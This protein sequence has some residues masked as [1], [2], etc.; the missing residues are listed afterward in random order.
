M[1]NQELIDYL[2]TLDL[3]VYKHASN[4]I[5]KFD[6]LSTLSQTQKNALPIIAN[7][8]F[9]FIS[10]NNQIIGYSEENIISRTVL[11]NNYY[12]FINANQYDNV[13]TSQGKFRPTILEEFM[14]ILFK[15]LINE[16]KVNL[17][18][19]NN[20]L[21]VGSSRA[22]TNLF[23]SGSNFQEFVNSPQIGI[24]DKDQDFAIYRPI[25]IT[26][27]DSNSIN[28]NLPIVAIENKTY[29]DK[30]MLEGSIATAEKVKSGNPYSLFFIVTENYDVDLK[31]DPIYSKIDQIYVLR[32][33]KRAKNQP[34][35]PIYSDVL[36]DLVS[37]VRIHLTRNWSD[38]SAKLSNTGKIL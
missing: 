2:K 5:A 8:Y 32:K 36:V 24:N 17:E 11:L 1:N 22:Y 19:V 26:I 27:G 35:Q 38:V 12:N 18:D 13:F 29:I 33:S 30:T 7:E 4:I 31:V 34:M 14:Y 3:S 20:N 16:V 9:N 28:T 10:A 6:N 25:S 21:R 15:D 37:E 23:F